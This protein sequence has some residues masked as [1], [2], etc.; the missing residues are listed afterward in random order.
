MLHACFERPSRLQVFAGWQ[1]LRL[2]FLHCL[3]STQAHHCCLDLYQ[4]PLGNIRHI[5]SGKT[6]WHPLSFDEVK[7]VCPG[8]SHP[9]SFG[10]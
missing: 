1:R 8:G 2:L 9:T 6:W 3:L 7:I 5:E 10:D 4:C